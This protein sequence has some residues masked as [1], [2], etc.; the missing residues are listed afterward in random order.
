MQC[1]GSLFNS[2]ITDIH[3]PLIS[4]SNTY[5]ASCAYVQFSCSF[6]FQK[7]IISRQNSLS[8]FKRVLFSLRTKFILSSMRRMKAL[9]I[10]KLLAL[11][12]SLHFLN[13]YFGFHQI[14]YFSRSVILM[15]T[16]ISSEINC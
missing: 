5:N 6:H 11:K 14:V 15:K 2:F 3:A 7:N 13:K 10:T 9:K 16:L 12:N 4:K 1:F 8:F